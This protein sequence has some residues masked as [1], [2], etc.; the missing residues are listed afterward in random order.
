[1][2]VLPGASSG[3]HDQSMGRATLELRDFP[4][5]P[6]VPLRLMSRLRAL[7]TFHTGTGLIRAA[8][9]PVA[10]VRFGPS[11]LL[12]PFVVVT[13]TRGARDV[14]GGNDSPF[15]K[16]GLIHV[17]S[18]ALGLNSF[19]MPNEPW[20]PRRRALQ[21]LFTKK[22]VAGFA[23]HMADAAD[24]LTQ[25]WIRQGVIDLNRQ[26]R[27]LTLRVIGGSVFGLDLGDRAQD[28]GPPIEQS[29]RWV[30]G[31]ATRPVRAP[32]WLPTPARRRLRASLTAIRAVTD[33]AIME[34]RA[35]PER[36]APLVRLL[37]DTADPDT[38]RPL[39]QQAVGEELTAFLVA[40]HDT[41]ATT[42]TYGLWALGRDRVIQDRVAAEVAD[43][44][45]RPLTVDDVAR[46]PYTLRVIQEALR[47]CPPAAVV[48]RMTMREAVVDGY[49]IPAGT[50][51]MVG[52]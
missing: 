39:S 7:R 14:L 19:N 21:R 29:L 12:A 18:R 13:S 31:R 42:L 49:R 15:D 20:R 3:C 48:T 26:C 22:H 8:G 36:D 50:N 28:L 27:R 33:Q 47:V 35:H 5:A 1:M 30:T 23:G 45:N 17:E 10:M 52:I 34:A 9:G 6:D 2:L 43:I 38:G 46:L 4:I 25:E 41:T 37:L 11:R 16:Q 51:V 24:T 40:G 44:A 32:Q